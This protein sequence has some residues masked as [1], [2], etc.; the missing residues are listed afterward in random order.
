MYSYILMPSKTQ[1]IYI[2]IYIYIYK[3]IDNISTFWQRVSAVK[4]HHQAKIEQCLCTRTMKVCTLW[5]PISFTVLG[6]LKVM[7]WLILKEESL[8]SIS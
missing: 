6:T 2:Y 1:H 4:S 8:K 7:C 3:Q 5:D